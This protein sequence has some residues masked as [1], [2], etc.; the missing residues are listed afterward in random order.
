MESGLCHHCLDGN[1]IL[2][3][4]LL[5]LCPHRC[6]AASFYNWS[7]TG[8]WLSLLC[9]A[10]G[11]FC[12]IITDMSTW[13]ICCMCASVCS[14][15]INQI[16]QTG[17]NC[18]LERPFQPR[19]QQIRICNQRA[20]T[21]RWHLCASSSHGSKGP[22]IRGFFMREVLHQYYFPESSLKYCNV[23]DYMSVW[24]LGKGT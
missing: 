14:D 5:L 20:L 3:M 17:Y 15:C 11:C 1:F 9:V 23:R 6:L 19:Q 8:M 12:A 22:G 16:P 24:R 10:F 21:H 2:N 18:L 13:D 7:V 4:S